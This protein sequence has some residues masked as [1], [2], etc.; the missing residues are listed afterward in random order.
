MIPTRYPGLINFAQRG[1]TLA[2]G[3]GEGEMDVGIDALGART[4]RIAYLKDGDRAGIMH[5]P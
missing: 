4:R 5:L 3:F 1:A 2:V